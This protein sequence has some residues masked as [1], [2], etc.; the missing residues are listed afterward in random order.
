GCHF[1]LSGN[2]TLPQQSKQHRKLLPH[3]KGFVQ[4]TPASNRGDK[5]FCVPG[6]RMSEISSLQ[7]EIF[8]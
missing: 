8:F 2:A 5:F 3:R 6:G 7:G 4:N 1:R